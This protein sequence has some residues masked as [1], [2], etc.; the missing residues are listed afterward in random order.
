MRQEYLSLDLVMAWDEWIL[1]LE[2]K[3]GAAS[4]TRNQWKTEYRIALKE[5]ER[6]KLLDLEDCR[7]KR[8]CV[9]Y[10]TPTESSGCVEFDSLGL[11]SE[12]SDAKVHLSWENVLEDLRQSFPD[13]TDDLLS[14]FIRGGCELTEA[15]LANRRKPVVKESLEREAMKLFV[16]EIRGKIRDMIRFDPTLELNDWHGKTE[17]VFG[18]IGGD[19]GNVYLNVYTDGTSLL[20]QEQ[21]KVR[22]SVS[23][24]VAGKAPKVRRDEFCSI[25][26]ENWTRILGSD[27]ADQATLDCNR[28]KFYVERDWEGQAAELADQL[29][30]LFCRFLLVFRPFMVNPRA[31]RVP[32]DETP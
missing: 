25:P 21:A 13:D 32:S 12:R 22:V 31:V 5:L 18:H 15:I 11:N 26:L 20:G 1:L 10:L 27:P 8:I 28:C 3:V 9:V 4:I 16:K 19:H 30:A 6:G 2:N 23:F 29:A 7:N 14:A 24:K 17:E